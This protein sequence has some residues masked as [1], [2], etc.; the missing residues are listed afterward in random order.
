MSTDLGLVAR[1]AC[2][3]LAGVAVFLEALVAATLF[4]HG[5]ERRRKA[6]PALICCLLLVVCM[7]CGLVALGWHSAGEAGVAQVIQGGP[8]PQASPFQTISGALVFCVADLI[9]VV[10]TVHAIYRMS[11]WAAL[12]CATTGYAL[13]NL[14][15]G[16]SETVAIV[17]DPSRARMGP[18]ASALTLACCALTYVVAWFLFIRRVDTRAL[19]GRLSATTILMFLV[20]AFG[21][22]GFDLILK[23]CV[24]GLV[25][26]IVMLY[27]RAFHALVCVFV[28]VAEVEL[29][30]VRQLEGQRSVTER[31]LAES[32]RQYRISRANRD[33]INARVHDMRH[34]VLGTLY[35]ANPDL[36][37]ST[38][39][40]VMRELDVYDSPVRTGNEA[41][42]V[43]L[44][45]KSLL[46]RAEG[47]T[48][49]CVADG[50]ALA[51]MSSADLYALFGGLLD[52]AIDSMRKLEERD[53]RT[54]SLVVRK[55]ANVVSVHVECYQEGETSSLDGVRAVVNR[56]DGILTA[57][58]ENHV[59]AL[60]VMIAV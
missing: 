19:D 47:I 38:A 59:L 60:D 46:C 3:A 14:A 40:A 49:T 28:I 37:R 20:V 35:A 33:A 32:E 55:H 53:L 21:V 5:R 22:I 1:V 42:D 24:E 31:L 52:C 25:P 50:K 2:Q 6:V 17:L 7:S 10:V 13:Q 41:L 15:S 29:V 26:R 11:W 16:L 58:T 36:N 4:A 45:E 39:A 30:V 43:V 57:S 8:Q 12:F 18:T 27:L 51:F 56:Y 9:L 23:D 48:L 34:D 44:T 54:I